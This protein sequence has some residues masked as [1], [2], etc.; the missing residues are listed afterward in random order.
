MHMDY[1]DCCYFSFWFLFSSYVYDGQ[2][3]PTNEKYKKYSGIGLKVY[4]K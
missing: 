3:V 2:N 1:R 4:V